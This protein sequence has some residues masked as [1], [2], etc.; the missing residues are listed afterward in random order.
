MAWWYGIAMMASSLA[1]A[2]GK[3]FAKSEAGQRL[4]NAIQKGMEDIEKEKKSNEI[5]RIIREQNVSEW[6]AL[7]IA[8]KAK[9]KKKMIRIF[10]ALTLLYFVIWYFIST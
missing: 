6:K 1:K 3:D 7:E 8:R 4:G 5:K 9:Q 10:I 2:A